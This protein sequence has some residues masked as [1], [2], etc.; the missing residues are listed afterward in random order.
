MVIK[1]DILLTLLS[2]SV[3]HARIEEKVFVGACANEKDS[4]CTE[5]Y[6]IK[7]SKEN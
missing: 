5:N 1:S 4:A 7:P 3:S 6:L 2:V